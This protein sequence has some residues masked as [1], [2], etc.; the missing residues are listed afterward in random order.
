MGRLEEKMA[1]AAGV[2]ER[3]TSDLESRADAVIAREA[4]IL[5][6]AK[7]WSD[8]KR[9]ILD[10]AEKAIDRAERALALLSNDP[11]PDSS[12]TPEASP[13]VG[14]PTAPAFQPQ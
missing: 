4:P 3:V 2:A 11:L 10:D 9:I 7:G 6:R 1:R 12:D 14:L 13:A 5:E 8:A